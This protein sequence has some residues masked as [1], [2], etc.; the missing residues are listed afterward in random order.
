M[1]AGSDGIIDRLPSTFTIQ[2]RA[3][4]M[5][6]RRRANHKALK[7]KRSLPVSKCVVGQREYSCQPYMAWVTEGAAGPHYIHRPHWRHWDAAI[8]SDFTRGKVVH[9]P[10]T[11]F[12]S[13]LDHEVLSFVETVHRTQLTTSLGG[14]LARL[15]ISCFFP[16]QPAIVYTILRSRSRHMDSGTASCCQD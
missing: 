10:T 4:S 5:E 8:S 2:S 12:R 13:S 11:P 6:P 16:C 15:A 1:A 7:R 9:S 3:S 14:L